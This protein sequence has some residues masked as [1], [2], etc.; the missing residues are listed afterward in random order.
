MKDVSDQ[1]QTVEIEFI[2]KP[3]VK[4]VDKF[5]CDNYMFVMLYVEKP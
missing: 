3:I 2:K 1:D 5:C 4:Q